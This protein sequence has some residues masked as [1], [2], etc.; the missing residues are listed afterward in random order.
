MAQAA[1]D[2]YFDT[3]SRKTQLLQNTLK[4]VSGQSPQTL[5][6]RPDDTLAA[7]AAISGNS[8]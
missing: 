6:P 7:L 3:E 5:I 2:R 4:D 8:R 1:L